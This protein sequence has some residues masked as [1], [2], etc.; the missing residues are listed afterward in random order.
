MHCFF[1]CV[2]NL[3]CLKFCL[4]DNIPK[5]Y[6]LGLLNR[7]SPP[8]VSAS[9]WQEGADPTYKGKLSL[10]FL[11]LGIHLDT[12]C[13]NYCLLQVRFLMEIW[14]VY[15]DLVHLYRSIALLPHDLGPKGFYSG[16]DKSDLEGL[17]WTLTMIGA[18]EGA[19]PGVAGRIRNLT[20][21]FEKWQ[22][23]LW[24]FCL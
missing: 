21:H 19:L 12:R 13:L 10:L 3:A 5:N 9:S 6:F 7:V 23:V 1:L 20:F 17:T 18:S 2:P 16:R 11:S 8:S 4:R 15:G 14:V 24:L 22:R